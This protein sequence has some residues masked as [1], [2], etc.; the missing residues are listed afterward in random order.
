VQDAAFDDRVRDREGR[1]ALER[2]LEIQGLPQRHAVAELVALRGGGAPE[3]L[4]R[5]H[6][7]GGPRDDPR[8]R[9]LTV[10]GRVPRAGHAGGQDVADEHRRHGVRGND[11]VV[12]EFVERRGP[13]QPEVDDARAPVLADE[14]VLGLHVAV[15]DARVVRG[16]EATADL[17]EH[18]HDL[19]P[20]AGG[21]AEPAAQ[22]G[23]L[24]ELH[25]DVDATRVG[26]HV[27][28]RHDVR[29][30][31][32]RERLRLTE[33]PLARRGAL[34][35][36][37]GVDEL[38]RDLTIQLRVEARVHD[39]HATFTEAAEHPV[40]PDRVR[41]S[42]GEAEGWVRRAQA[43]ANVTRVCARGRC[44]V[45]GSRWRGPRRDPVTD[46]RCR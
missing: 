34:G 15:H 11:L 4:F 35:E 16:G 9:D 27:V 26:A 25:R 30:G 14:D 32:A 5:R 23:T 13:R 36:L 45:G 8:A 18:A 20:R 39:G 29:V 28:D 17:Q 43:S 1:L 12:V 21:L 24:D 44:P 41:I 19:P 3:V 7:C 37:V 38:D 33:Q 6:V 2:A 31:D 22:R 40:P 10:Q 46:R 42:R